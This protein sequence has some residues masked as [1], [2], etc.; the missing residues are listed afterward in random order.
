M[1]K[2]QLRGTFIL[3]S[4]GRYYKVITVRPTGQST[5]LFDCVELETKRSEV[6]TLRMHGLLEA[7]NIAFQ[8][9]NSPKDM[10]MMDLDHGGAWKTVPKEQI[11]KMEK[12]FGKI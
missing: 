3:K 4:K 11:E 2:F 5:Y 8:Y 10:L 1:S 6:L 9:M 7:V 12:E